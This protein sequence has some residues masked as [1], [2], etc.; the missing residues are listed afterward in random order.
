ME[1]FQ[2]AGIAS[3]FDWK[4]MVDQL[5]AI[6]RFPQNRMRDEQNENKDKLSDLSTLETKLGN[7]KTSLTDFQDSSIFNSKSVSL[8]QDT[9]GITATAGTSAGIGNYSVNVSQLAT[10]TRRIGTADVGG[11]IG[12]AATVI[13]NLRLATDITAGDFTINGQTVTV[14]TTDTLQDV[15]DAISTATGGVVTAAYDGPTDKVTLTSSSGELDLG[16]SADDSNFLTALKLDQLEVVDAGGGATSVTSTKELGVVDINDSIANSGI[17]GPITG[18]G[19]LLVNGVAIDFD[20]D[21]DSMQT[22]MNRVNASDADVT[23]TYDSVADQFRINN[24]ETGAY[25]MAVTDSGNGLLAALGLNGLATVGNDLTFSIDGGAN[26]TARSNTITDADHGIV[27]LSITATETGT[28]TISIG[29]DSSGLKEKISKFISSYNDVQDFILEKTKIEVEDDV[30][31]AGSLAGNREIS[32]LDSNLRSFAFG[33]IAGMTGDIFRLEHMGIDFISG[34]SKLEVKDSTDLDDA[35]AGD[36][37]ELETFF[38]GG[39]TSFSERMEDYITNFTDTDGILDIQKET[40]N[41]QNKR[42]DEQIAEMERR[43]EFQ[44][45]ALEASFIAMEEAQSNISQQSTA[46]AGLLNGGFA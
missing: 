19:T 6:E 36:L 13:S 37:S 40:L 5:I 8:S 25:E 22:L 2:V 31:T 15:F 41:S 44:K 28:Q 7:L 10:A 16:G 20:A 45:A 12:S 18:T 46:L 35:L 38:N 4:T 27:G 33:A 23:M 42:I 43:I 24:N 3:G 26:Q 9:L 11:N 21:T 17:T 32:S 34:T 29:R 1:R 14:A 39:A 30:V